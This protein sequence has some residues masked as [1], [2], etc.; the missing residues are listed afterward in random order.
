MKK[1]TIPLLLKREIYWE[2]C[3]KYGSTYCSFCENCKAPC[4]SIELIENKFS[5]PENLLIILRNHEEAHF[6]HIIPESR[7]GETIKKNLQIYCRY[8]NLKK[9]NDNDSV[10]RN[11]MDCMNIVVD[12]QQEFISKDKNKMNGVD[13]PGSIY[14][15]WMKN[16]GR[17]CRF[18]CIR[19]TGYC[20]MH[21]GQ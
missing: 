14:C 18:R 20:L 8:C 4:R 11:H 6:D 16:D 5:I 21:S 13:R 1:A 3:R 19:E 15:S 17:E 10:F 12:P 7:G 9:G 2:N